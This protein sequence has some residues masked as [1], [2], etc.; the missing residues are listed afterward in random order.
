[1]GGWN[2]VADESR[3]VVMNWD[4]NIQIRVTQLGISHKDIA[5]ALGVSAQA[6][7][8][9][10]TGTNPTL[11]TIRMVGMVLA[12]PWH[13]L[14]QEDISAVV[15][16]SVPEWDWLGFIKG[17]QESGKLGGLTWEDVERHQY[18]GRPLQVRGSDETIIMVRD[19]GEQ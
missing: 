4:R 18:S 2:G 12:C 13:L 3:E 9:M 10:R 7:Y 1:M 16:Q 17:Q 6:W 11:K 19:K 8:G 14:L 5:D 15:G